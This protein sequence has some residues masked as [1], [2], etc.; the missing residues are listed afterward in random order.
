MPAN[1]P[2]FYVSD[3]WIT[4]SRGSMFNGGT[5]TSIG[6]QT[7]A[8]NVNG[9]IIINPTTGYPVLNSI[10]TPTGD[11][12]PNYTLGINNQISYKNWNFSVL[13]DYRNGG[14][15]FNVN[16][17]YRTRRG[18]SARTL[19]RET[20]RI[21]PGV[22]NDANVN[23]ATPTRN[24]ISITPMFR[25][26]YW[27]TIAED[28]FIERNIKWLRLR[29][30]TISYNVPKS[31]L[32]KSKFISGLNI[33]ATGTDLFLITNYSGMDPLTNSNTPATPGVGGFGFDFGTVPL[34]RTF[35]LGVRATF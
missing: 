31:M 34:P 1:L 14:D 33:Y 5:T 13:L 16:E 27:G 10:Y 2:E 25:S 4:N 23:S 20:P 30:V 32:N 18:Y 22:L 29:D 15:I 12:N 21:I 19:D 9:D 3:T 8:R 11:R 26:D 6:G 7:Y 24:T 28:E 35:L 17:L